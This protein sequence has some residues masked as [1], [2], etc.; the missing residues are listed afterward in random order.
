ML[1]QICACLQL[2][3]NQKELQ[4]S[5]FSAWDT[6]LRTLDDEDVEP[7]LES[8]LSAIIQHWSSFEESVRDQA[9]ATLRYLLKDRTRL[10]RNTIA[11]LPSL[12]SIPILADFEAQLLKLR[13]PTDLGNAFQI[14]TRRLGHENSSVVT[15][16]LVEL[17]AF[18]QTHQTFL[19]ASA[20]SEQP[21]IVV[22]QLVRAILDTCVK[23]NESDYATT[24]LSAECLGLIGCL[25]PNRVESDREYREMVV[26][27]NFG[28]V[29]ET[30]DFVLYLLEKV[31]VPEFLSAADTSLQGFLSYVM[32]ELLL[33][34]EFKQ[35]CTVEGGPR[36]NHDRLYN[37]WKELPDSVKDTL[38][39]FLE[40]KFR[41]QDRVFPDCHYPLFRPQETGS[42][43]LYKPW[44]AKFVLDLLRKHS[45]FTTSL[46]FPI[47]CRA[48]RMKS[49]SIAN[50]LLPYVVLYVIIEGT[51]KDRDEIGSELLHVLQY[52]APPDSHVR[53]E[54]LKLCV[55]V[56]TKIRSATVTNMIGYLS[57]PGV[58]GS[59]DTRKAFTG[60]S[61]A[62]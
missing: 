15:Q 53:R 52:E 29:D 9:R 45:N 25:D 20:V 27:S 31:I 34:F 19:Q 13:S 12:S 3:L 14:Y 26:V 40:S 51:D 28:D 36:T 17:K 55:E 39:P 46:M 41:L 18:L 59:V 61:L 47:L 42:R 24:Q 6:T 2:A 1:S 43:A 10:V 56:S 7:M 49:I 11:H 22:G 37:K 30:T 33:V 44:I 8:T 60:Q 32:Q 21:E 50:F 54:D 4:G 23:F 35:A 58:S 48:I 38:T 57:Y 5:A 62:T 16:A